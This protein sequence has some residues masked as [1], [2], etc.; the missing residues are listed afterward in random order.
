MPTGRAEEV[1]SVRSEEAHVGA[2]VKVVEDFRI[3]ELRGMIGTVKQTYG[4]PS[5]RALEVRLDGGR[6]E[7]FW[8]H[9]LEK[10]EE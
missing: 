1:G 5:Y 2:R 6:S 9:E 3:P 4:D 10:V 7:L 8:H